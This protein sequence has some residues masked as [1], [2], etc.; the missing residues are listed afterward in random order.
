M[1]KLALDFAIKVA[2]V[3]GDVVPEQWI[4]ISSKMKIPFDQTLQ[5]HPEYDGYDGHIIRQV[6]GC[7]C[8][9]QMLTVAILGGCDFARISVEFSDEQTSATKRPRL[10]F[11]EN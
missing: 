1:A 8:I 3:V 11:I 10:L 7:D 2:T 9:L 4:D 6:W 5:I